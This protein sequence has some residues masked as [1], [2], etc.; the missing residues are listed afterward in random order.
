MISRLLMGSEMILNILGG[1]RVQRHNIGVGSR[2]QVCRLMEISARVGSVFETRYRKLASVFAALARSFHKTTRS[3]AVISMMDRQMPNIIG[4]MN[5]LIAI[6]YSEGEVRLTG[7]FLN[8]G[9]YMQ[10]RGLWSL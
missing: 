5:R 8:M 9:D 6:P 10:M 1:V 7:L 3:P 2:L 4:V